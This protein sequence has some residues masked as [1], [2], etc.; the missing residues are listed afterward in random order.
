[1][2]AGSIRDDV[3]LPDVITDAVAAQ[4][5]MRGLIPGVGMAIMVGSTL[6]A[7]ATGNLLPARVFTVCVDINPGAVTKLQDRG[8]RQSVG[9]VM[10]AASFLEQLAA[11]LPEEGPAGKGS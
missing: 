9:I 3:P 2:L 7:V 10:D 11:G 1:M 4:Q 5:A 8:S 6:H